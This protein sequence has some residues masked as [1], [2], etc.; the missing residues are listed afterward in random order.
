MSTSSEDSGMARS[1]LVG[2]AFMIAGVSL[3]PVMNSLAKFLTADFP[4]WQVTWARFTG[5]LLVIIVVFMPRRGLALFA[6]N[7]PRGQLMR[8]T[9]FFGSNVC[10]VAALPFIDLATAAAIVFTAPVIVTVLSVI[11]LKE[12]VGVWRWG[13]VLLGFAGALVVIQPGGD[14]FNFATLLVL[15]AATCYSIYQL[16]T[17]QLVNSDQ[18]DTQ[19]AWTALVGTLITC[20]IVPFVG[21]MP[22]TLAQVAAFAGMGSL[23]AVSHFLVIQALKRAPASVVSPIGYVELLGATAIGFFAFGE[24]PGPNTWAG[25]ALIVVSGLVIAYRQA[26]HARRRAGESDD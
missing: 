13:A 9:V 18:P 17:R 11:F 2:I 22:D 21:K 16:Q 23:G 6:T 3:F 12:K 5:H 10:F 14:D 26:F 15:G 7:R 25:A 4:V 24:L 20:A 8:S 19:I 1:V